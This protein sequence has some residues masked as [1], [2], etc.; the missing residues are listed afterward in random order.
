M[1]TMSIWVGALLLA[2]REGHALAQL[3]SAELRAVAQARAAAAAER[4]HPDTH[5]RGGMRYY[6]PAD[7]QTRYQPPPASIGEAPEQL[8]YM[9]PRSSALSDA[10]RT[11]SVRGLDSRRECGTRR[12]RRRS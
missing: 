3:T 9:S 5:G 8:K 11:A 7:G 1:K 6:G 2:G 4:A 12:R 10:L